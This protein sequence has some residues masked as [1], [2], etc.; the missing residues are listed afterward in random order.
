MLRVEILK[1]VHVVI[2][3]CQFPCIN[4]LICRLS[5][6]PTNSGIEFINT[7]LS[8]VRETH[9]SVRRITK[10]CINIC[11]SD[12]WFYLKRSPLMVNPIRLTKGVG[13]FHGHSMV[14]TSL[15]QH[16]P[17]TRRFDSSENWLN[18]RWLTSV[19]AREMVFPSWYKPLFRILTRF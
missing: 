8:F 7:G 17:L 13:Y 3:P 14:G 12:S 2:R 1:I 4:Q 10:L 19:I 5:N 9:Q 6:I 18:S 15:Q 11:Y 16:L